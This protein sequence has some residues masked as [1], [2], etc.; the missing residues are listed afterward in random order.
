MRV[1]IRKPGKYTHLKPDLHLTPEKLREL[2]LKLEKLKQ[3]HPGLA[4]E[5]NRLAQLGDLSENAGYQI[6]KG[7][8][9]G[10]NDKITELEDRIK[11]AEVI[12]PDKSSDKVQL[13]SRVTVEIF[14]KEQTY[15]V[16]GSSETDPVNNIISHNS[17]VG[18]AIMDAKVGDEVSYQIKDKEVK[19]KIIKIV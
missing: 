9:R 8:L 5:V 1:P 11:R 19:I 2:E 14:G 18:S 7:R 10:V 13:G 15:L 12:I 16:L 4:A 17:P 3:Q 6:A